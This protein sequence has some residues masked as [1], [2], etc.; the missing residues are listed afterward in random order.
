M[1]IISDGVILYY[2]SSITTFFA[3]SQANFIPGINLE[4]YLEYTPIQRQL[5]SHLLTLGVST[6]ACGFV[7][8]IV[9]LKRSAPRYQISSILS[10]VVMVS[11]FLILFRQLNGWLDAFEFDGRVWRLTVSELGTFTESTFNNGYRYLNW[12]IDVPLLL[13][14][15]LFLF[16]LNRGH[17]RRLRIKFITAGLLM[18]YTGYIGQYFELSNIPAFLIWGLI[19][20]VFYVYILFLVGNVIG[21][22]GQSLPEKPAKMF[23]GVWWLLLISWTLYPLAYLVPFGWHLYP[24][25]GGWAAVT[26][27]FLFTMADIFSKVVYGVLLTNIAQTRS[28]I[29]QYPPALEVGDEPIKNYYRE[30]EYTER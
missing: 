2:F 22:S 9:T 16:D 6:M 20:T 1:D 15:M 12:S 23:K 7:Y 14:Q 11:A 13:T 10:A 30:R 8:F 19:S 18:I 27:Q 21:K 3:Q 24:A 4:N 28:Q 29:E 25:W 5:I 17:K 26:R